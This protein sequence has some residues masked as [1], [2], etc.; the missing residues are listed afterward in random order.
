[1]ELAVVIPLTKMWFVAD[2]WGQSELSNTKIFAEYDLIKKQLTWKK[3]SKKN[4]VSQENMLRKLLVLLPFSSPFVIVPLI[5]FL[6]NYTKIQA[7]PTE[8]LGNFSLLAPLLVGVLLFLIFEYFMLY[9]RKNTEVVDVPSKYNQYTYFEELYEHSVKNNDA[10]G[11]YK[12][13]YLI[14]GLAI[15][16]LAVVAI[17]IMF[18]LY[19]MLG[20]F[21][22]F[23]LKLIILSFLLSVLLLTIWNSI[24]KGIITKKIINKLA[25]ELEIQ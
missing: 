22:E 13:P 17:P 7:T 10:I 20:T 18:W 1:M 2:Y 19:N 11:K 9:R 16:F 3:F 15:I 8:R 24:I 21:G 6:G 23:M 25:E 5:G 4:I 12:T 14:T